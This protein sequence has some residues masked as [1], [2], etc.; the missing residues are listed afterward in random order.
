MALL[1]CPVDLYVLTREEVERS[2]RQASPLVRLALTTGVDLLRSRIIP[3]GMSASAAGARRSD[4]LTPHLESSSTTRFNEKEGGSGSCER[5]EEL[6][7]VFLVYILTSGSEA[8]PVL[9]DI[10][11]FIT[12]RTSFIESR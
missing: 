2:R 6:L 8:P 3:P 1:P 7:E 5:F 10:P 12:K 4:T 9:H 11:A